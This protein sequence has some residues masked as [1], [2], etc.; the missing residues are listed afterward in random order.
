MELGDA[1]N[2]IKLFISFLFRNLNY[3]SELEKDL[4]KNMIHPIVITRESAK[5]I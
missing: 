5:N 2:S 4:G 3:D 1:Q